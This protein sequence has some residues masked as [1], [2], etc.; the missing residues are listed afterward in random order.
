MGPR[1]LALHN[2]AFLL[3]L[4]QDARDA[5]ASNTFSAWSSA[6][7]ARYRDRAKSKA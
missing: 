5:L 4:M 1:L 2:L 6:W 3:K 7:L